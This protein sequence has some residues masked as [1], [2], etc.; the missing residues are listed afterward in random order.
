M[1]GVSQLVIIFVF[2]LVVAGVVWLGVMQARAD[3]QK[4]QGL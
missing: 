4:R 2:G 3:A 1:F